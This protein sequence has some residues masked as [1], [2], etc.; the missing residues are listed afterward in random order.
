VGHSCQSK[1]GGYASLSHALMHINDRIPSFATGT[2][3]VQA[4]AT[5][6]KCDRLHSP[7]C[8]WKAGYGATFR[9]EC[10]L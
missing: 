3:C 7:F 6:Y 5:R 2:G 10:S 9:D 1:L 4:G 8:P